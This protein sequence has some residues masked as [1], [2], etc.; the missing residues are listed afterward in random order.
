MDE[1]QQNKTRLL[2][3]AILA[4]MVGVGAIYLVPIVLQMVLDIVA[5]ILLSIIGLALV[6]LLPAIAE[7]LS[8]WAIRLWATAI[9]TDPIARLWKDVREHD[10]S[11]E[12]LETQIA[13]AQA[14]IDSL[15]QQLEEATNVL[16][17]EDLVA[18]RAQISELHE[19][20]DE[21]VRVHEDEV[22]NNQEFKLMVKRAETEYKLGNAFARAFAVVT[23]RKEGPKSLGSRLALEEVRSRLANSQA[24]LKLTMNRARIERQGRGPAA[25]PAPQTMQILPAPERD[26][27]KRKERR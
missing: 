24:R 13:E 14:E 3:Y 10:K 9:K 16:P 15:E 19:S 23:N 22:K 2:K 27:A 25:L 20:E 17:P 7:W 8:L 1:S 11:V 18:Y 5:I 4:A 12:A 6:L 21:M 26:A